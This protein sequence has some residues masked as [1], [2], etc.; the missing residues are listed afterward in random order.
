[1][2]NSKKVN[3]IVLRTAGTNCDQETC[4]AFKLAGA[5]RVD[6]V[7]VN[8]LVRR[9]VKL[10]QYQILAI[11]AGFS[12]GDD[13]S[14]GKISTQLKYKL[15]KDV[16]EFD[17]EGKLIM[18]ICNGFQVLV[19]LGLLPGVVRFSKYVRSHK[20]RH[21]IRDSVYK[22]SATLSWN[23]SGRFEC[24]WVYLKAV[25]S[26]YSWTEGLPKIVQLPVAHA[27]GKFIVGEKKLL[28]EL[29]KNG[30]IVFKYVDEKGALRTGHPYN[31]NGSMGNIAGITNRRGNIFG[32]MPHP[33]RFVMKYQF[34]WWTRMGP[35][36]SL[37]GVGLQIFRNAVHM[38]SCLDI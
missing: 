12:Y 36:F 17:N 35:A 9:E 24:R 8:Q 31:P 3:A 14:A 13:V 22:R 30:Q 16:K 4:A 38:G 26:R 29:E 25:G 28:D 20:M 37:K 27:E 2:N 33:E 21:A 7:H 11:P 32:L 23:N 1:M 19:K 5:D 18:G 6:L 34:P 10:K 15:L